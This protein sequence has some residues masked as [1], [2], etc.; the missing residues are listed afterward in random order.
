[1]SELIS[2]KDTM[3]IQ[4][5]HRLEKCTGLKSTTTSAHLAYTTRAGAPLTVFI[6]TGKFDAKKHVIR[7]SD[8]SYNA[9]GKKPTI[10]YSTNTHRIDGKK[11]YGTDGD[12]PTNELKELLVIW[13]GK[14][15]AVPL[16]SVS[17]CYELHPKSMEVY[18]TPQLLYVYLSGSDGAGGYSVKFVFNHNNYITRIISRNEC[19]DGYDFIDALPDECI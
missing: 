15:V 9:T 17:N 19:T 13:N 18:C 14:H 1:M 10:D 7:F 8:T 16:D 5:R 12:L 2:P 4:N 6:Q 3:Y 11:F